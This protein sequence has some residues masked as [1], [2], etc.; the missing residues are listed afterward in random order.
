MIFS[1]FISDSVS[2][3]SECLTL[4]IRASFFLIVCFIFA[5]PVKVMSVE[6]EKLLMMYTKLEVELENTINKNKD[7]KPL[8]LKKVAAI[9]SNLVDVSISDVAYILAYRCSLEA[10]QKKWSELDV[11]R[12]KL[13]NLIVLSDEV[14]FCLFR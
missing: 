2:Y 1:R 6:E 5:M 13:S 7:D 4:S 14:F 11:T 3:Q 8:L 12:K 9:E 10:S